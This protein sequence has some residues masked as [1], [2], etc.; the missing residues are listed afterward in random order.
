MIPFNFERQELHHNNSDKKS[1]VTDV[2][3]KDESYKLGTFHQDLRY[4]MKYEIRRRD[5]G[6]DIVV[7]TMAKIK[8]KNL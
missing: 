5:L 2:L 8:K 4:H 3:E 6:F 7:L 1:N